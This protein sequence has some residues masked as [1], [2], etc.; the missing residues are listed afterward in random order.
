MAKGINEGDVIE[1]IFGICLSLY[2][3]KK[4]FTENEVATIRA[5]IDPKKFVGGK[6][7][8]IPIAKKIPKQSSKG[9]FPTD[10]FD[11][12]LLLKMKPKATTLA[13]GQDFM[14]SE[15]YR[16]S[17]ASD[18]SFQVVYDS[19]KDIGKIGKKT[20]Q[21]V[22]AF[23]S[24]SKAKADVKKSI[25]IFLKNHLSETVEFIVEVDGITGSAYAGT[26]K[27]DVFMHVTAVVNGK[28]Q[29]LKD[30]TIGF[31]IKSDSSTYANLS[32]YN[33][34][35]EFAKLFGVKLKNPEVYDFLK[36]DA[37]KMTPDEVKAKQVLSYKMFE[38]IIEAV[39]KKKNDPNF[40][41][42]IFNYL[43]KSI[44][45]TDT[46]LVVHV[47]EGSIK[48]LKIDAFTMLKNTV[49]IT[50]S[51]ELEGKEKNRKKLVF[52]GKTMNGTK[53]LCDIRIKISTENA[54]SNEVK[55]MVDGGDLLK[56]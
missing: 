55:I 1:G 33:G 23:N 47:S 41:Q 49:K 17:K 32:P 12:N 22:N 27:A 56:T 5:K 3:A 15:A 10:Y 42:V 51:L 52:Y 6:G 29:R 21:I 25:D 16:K 43:E 20:K 34:M 11:V 13:Y 24:A 53:K 48:E 54:K 31:S 8:K 38:E 26:I 28:P 36:R 14:K 35:M 30:L 50:S 37:K 19:V 45:G 4:T 7:V 9:D 2:I 39:D 40:S 18:G 44:F 46:P